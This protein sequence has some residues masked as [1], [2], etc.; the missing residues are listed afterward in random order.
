LHRLLVDKSVQH[1]DAPHRVQ[2]LKVLLARHLSIT[3]IT[4]VIITIIINLI[5]LLLLPIGP[6]I[7][8]EFNPIT[9]L[10]LGFAGSAAC[11]A[12]ANWG[13]VFFRSSRF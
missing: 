7:A 12:W 1:V 9:L 6:M 10:C 8:G 13:G 5:I 3:T 11:R 2:L 4:I